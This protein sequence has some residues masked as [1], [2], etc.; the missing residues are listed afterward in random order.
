MI[1]VIYPRFKN[2]IEFFFYK[3]F[4]SKI[5]IYNMPYICPPLITNSGNAG[6]LHQLVNSSNQLLLGQKVYSYTAPK[7]IGTS[8]PYIQQVIDFTANFNNGLNIPF[9]SGQY[10]VYNTLDYSPSP[11]VT[12]WVSSSAVISWDLEAYL[13]N[14]DGKMSGSGFVTTGAGIANKACG[15]FSNTEESANA[16]F[17]VLNKLNAFQYNATNATTLD[18][19]LTIEIRYLAPL[20]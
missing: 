6:D 17:E 2:N 11:P 4:F 1:N 10:L 9:P 15:I 7:V 13:A 19:I 20:S 5:N 14:G 12:L 3:I 16:A 8:S 18:T